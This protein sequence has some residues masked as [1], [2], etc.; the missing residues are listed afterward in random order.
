[1]AEGK[2]KVK[3]YELFTEQEHK[4]IGSS[5]GPKYLREPYKPLAVVDNK[6]S[7]EE[8][9]KLRREHFKGKSI[10]GIVNYYGVEGAF[11]EI[12][13][14]PINTNPKSKNYGCTQR[15]PVLLSTDREGGIEDERDKFPY[16]RSKPKVKISGLEKK[17]LG[18]IAI[19]WFILSVFF[20]SGITGNIIG[21]STANS[22][23]GA[24][25][26]ILSLVF[27]FFYFRKKYKP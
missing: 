13:I 16:K 5:T 19:G 18:I 25:F 21:N 20:L 14:E 26:F 2:K 12:S 10:G 22:L 27:T 24:V 7:P 6:L 8:C 1:M 4:L 17:V 11:G 23:M 9:D 15:D 3:E